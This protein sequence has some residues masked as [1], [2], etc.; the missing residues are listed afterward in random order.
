MFGTVMGA[1]QSYPIAWPP[2]STGKPFAVSEE[3]RLYA[4]VPAHVREQDVLVT[5]TPIHQWDISTGS[6]SSEVG[7]LFNWFYLQGVR[8]R[9]Q[10]EV[11]GYLLRFPDIIEA[12][13]QAVLIAKDRLQEAQLQLEVYRDPEGE[14]EHLVLYA[15]FPVYDETVME[16]IRFA[17][18]QYRHLLRGKSGWLILTTDFH[19][20][21]AGGGCLSIGQ[22]S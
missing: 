19:Q 10:G 5:A 20:P 11:Y 7:R 18:R 6:L 12:V 9:Q 8:V 15:R 2:S 22:N 1:N 4:Q 14:D 13:K 21:E 17:R 16:R 3:P